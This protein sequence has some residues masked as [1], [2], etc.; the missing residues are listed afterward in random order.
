VKALVQAGLPVGEALAVALGAANAGCVP[1]ERAERPGAA[2]TALPASENPRVYQALPRSPDM[3]PAPSAAPSDVLLAEPFRDDFQRAT[4]GND[5][6]PT[7]AAW[8]LE[9]GAL[10]GQAA[11]NRPVW[12]ARRLPTN[13]A[14]A[15][16]AVSYSREGDLKIELFGDGQSAAT[17]TVY[18][19]ATGYVF[20]YGGWKN[21]LHVLARL[22][23]HGSDRLERR[24]E[25]SGSDQR[26]LAVVPGQRYRFGIERRD[27]KT[28]KWFVDGTEIYT[29]AD[30][31]PLVGGGHEYFAFN[32]WQARVCF[33]NLSVVPLKG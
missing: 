29:L 18:D 27:G 8:S 24:I 19:D 26:A 15:F 7:S 31:S 12:L 33:D 17:S 5:Y 32:G 28:V 2:E 14:I 1:E 4:L 23:E 6:R 13:V 16:D 10:C 21:S 25:P 9:G 22:D 11:G 30:E 20:I 3:A